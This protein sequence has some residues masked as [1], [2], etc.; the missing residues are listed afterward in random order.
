MMT[1]IRICSEHWHAVERD[2]MAL[3]WL[4]SA[5]DQQFF[6]VVNG[7]KL[8][9]WQLISIVVTSPPGTA[10]YH[11]STRGDTPWTPEAQLMANL[12]E[13]QAGVLGLNARYQRPGVDSTP[14][15]RQKVNSFDALP[16][17]GGMKLDALPVTELITRREELAKAARES[18]SKDRT[19]FDKYGAKQRMTI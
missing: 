2:C 10:V 3:N 6:H 4:W 16:D 13:Q 5:D 18:G 1:L 11:A 14:P 15:P 19:M 17:Y 7:V 9:V 8:S 12:G